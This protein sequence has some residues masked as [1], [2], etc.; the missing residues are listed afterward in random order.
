MRKLAKGVRNM[1]SPSWAPLLQKVPKTPQ[2]TAASLAMACPECG[3]WWGGAK[4]CHCSSCHETF[5]TASAFDKHRAGSFTA[6][7]RHCV[8]PAQVGLIDAG[9]AYPC[10]GWAVRVT[11]ESWAH[12]N[13]NDEL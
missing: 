3:G 8:D 2:I 4:T 1:S 10:W 7:N 13:G 9:R 11:G 6:N 5:T 12:P